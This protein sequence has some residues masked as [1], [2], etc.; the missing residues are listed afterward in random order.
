[1]GFIMRT[2]G[3]YLIWTWLAHH[4]HHTNATFFRRATLQS[5]PRDLKPY[6]WYWMAGYQ[7][8]LIKV[9]TFLVVTVGFWGWF[10]EHT[11]TVYTLCAVTLLAIVMGGWQGYRSF[12]IRTHTREVVNPIHHTL[13]H[14]LGYY[15]PRAEEWVTVPTDYKSEDSSGTV[16]KLPTGV[17]VAADLQKVITEL[18]GYKLELPE[19]SVSWHLSG[20]EPYVVFRAEP[21]CPPSVSFADIAELIRNTPDTAPIIGL[22]KRNKPVYLDLESDSPHILISAGSGGGKSVLAQCIIAQQL[23]HGAEVHIFDRKRISHRWVKGLPGAH[24][25]RD[26]PE[27]HQA[28]VNLAAEGDRRNRLTDHDDDPDLG[29]R[30]FVVF[31]EMNATMGKMK[32]YWDGVREKDEPRRSPAIEA[33]GDLVNMGRQ[34][35]INVLAIGQ[36]IETRTLGG[37]DIRESFGI[38]CLSRYSFNTW[39]M[40]CAEIAPM[41]KKSSVRG[42]WQIVSNGESV[43]TQVVFMTDSEARELSM[44]RADQADKAGTPGVG[45]ETLVTQSEVFGDGY[46]RLRKAAQRDPEFPAPAMSVSGGSNLYRRVDIEQWLEGRDAGQLTDRHQGAAA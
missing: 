22:T 13:G 11:A 29:P 30:I 41:P 39:K 24:Y 10:F 5:K 36:R 18:V 27:I 23:R 38:R 34:V 26:A 4:T 17:P 2:V 33:L 25:Y 1:M 14:Q 6:P 42:R 40:L 21:Q 35:S 9:T 31:E 20:A 12:R 46:E 37:G 43:P 16:I 28:L 7:R 32:T 45:T 44:E 3:R 8:M 19:M 15:P